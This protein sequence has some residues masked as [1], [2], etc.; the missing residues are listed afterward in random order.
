MVIKAASRGKNIHTPQQLRSWFKPKRYVYLWLPKIDCQLFLEKQLLRLVKY[1]Q[2]H[3]ANVSWFSALVPCMTLALTKYIYNV[4]FNAAF[5]LQ[6][7]TMPLQILY[8]WLIV[9]TWLLTD[10]I[11]IAYWVC[12]KLSKRVWMCHLLIFQHVWCNLVPVCKRSCIIIP[13]IFWRRIPQD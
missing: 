5:V 3:R 9:L 10:H 12:L 11:Y 8:A 6:N 13:Y 2:V 4:D 7:W 1:G